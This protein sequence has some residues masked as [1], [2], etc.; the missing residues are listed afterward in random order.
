MDVVKRIKW[1][2]YVPV[3]PVFVGFNFKTE[4][5]PDTSEQIPNTDPTFIST[6]V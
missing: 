4:R 1:L 6:K 5:E 3:C 2:K